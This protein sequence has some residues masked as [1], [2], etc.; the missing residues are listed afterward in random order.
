MFNSCVSRARFFFYSHL[1]PGGFT[2]FGVLFAYLRSSI[3]YLFARE[4][5]L[6]GSITAILDI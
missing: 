1:L 2:V 3:L 5:G 6:R 4:L